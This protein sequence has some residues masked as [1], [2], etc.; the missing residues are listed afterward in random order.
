MGERA[1]VDVPMTVELLTPDYPH[2]GQSSPKTTDFQS[3]EDFG[4]RSDT[5]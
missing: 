3:L 2:V 1:S 5:G 4:S